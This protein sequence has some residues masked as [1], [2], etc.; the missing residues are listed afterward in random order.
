MKKLIVSFLTLASLSVCVPAFAQSSPGF[1]NVV[2]GDQVVTEPVEA[3]FGTLRLLELVDHEEVRP[4]Y[5]AL[6]ELGAITVSVQKLPAESDRTGKITKYTFTAHE[7]TG[8]F[9]SRIAGKLTVET[10]DL[11]GYADGGPSIVRVGALEKISE[12]E[13]DAE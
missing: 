10:F 11:L 9:S 5:N 1:D 13:S 7:R 8:M 4:A 3:G 12:S 2:W 6:K